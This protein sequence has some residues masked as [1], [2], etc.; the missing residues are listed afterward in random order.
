M[1]RNRVPQK[2]ADLIVEI[3][4]SL[5]EQP[6]YALAKE[7]KRRVPELSFKTALDYILSAGSEGILEKIGTNFKAR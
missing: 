5:G 3:A 4:R 6:R 1:K 2:H 7:L